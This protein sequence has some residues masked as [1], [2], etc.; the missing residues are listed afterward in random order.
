MGVKELLKPLDDVFNESLDQVIAPSLGKIYGYMKGLEKPESE[1]DEYIYDLYGK[2]RKFFS[3]TYITSGME[4]VFNEVIKALE[5]SSTG[6]IILP[7]LFGGGK[8]HL[9]LALLHAFQDPEAIL[10]AEPKDTAEKLYENLKNLL[11]SKK[12]DKIDIVVIDGDYEKYAPSPIKPLNVGPYTVYTIW[13]YIAHSLG[14]Y[15]IVRDYDEKQAAPSEDALEDLFRDKHALILM[16]EV[17]SGYAVNLDNTQR[18]KL[19]EFFKRLASALQGKNIATVITIPAYYREQTGG[20]ETDELYKD[21]DDFIEVLF[22]AVREQ[23]VIVPPVRYAEEYGG[24]DVVKI[25]RKRIFGEAEISVPADKISDIISHY[26]GVYSLGMFPSTARQIE[27]LKEY[28]PFHPTYIDILIRHI[29]ERRPTTFQRT[30]F[31]ILI[32]RK[33]IRN[34]WQSNRDPD[35]IHAW[36]IDLENGDISAAI[37]GKLQEK[38]Y[39]GYVNKLYEVT[40]KFVN[41]EENL[42]KDIITT[43]FLRTFLYEGASEATKAYPTVNEVYWAVYDR[44]HNVEPARLELVLDKL[45]EDPDASYIVKGD[46]KVY[47]TTLVDIGEILKKRVEEALKSYKN[48]VVEKLK[49]ELKEVLV[50][51]DEPHEPFSK[52]YTTFM[53]SVDL[54]AGFK[55]E[56][57]PEHKAIV[58]LGQLEDSQ[59]AHNLIL[60]YKN[61][62]NVV[63]VLDSSDNKGFEEL[64][65]AAAWLYVIDNI[66]KKNEL[67]EMYPDENIRKWN[68]DK[69]K[70]IR[71]KKLNDLKNLATKVLNRVWYPNEEN[72]SYTQVTVSKK[73]LLGNIRDA[74]IGEKILDPDQ[75]DLKVFLEKLGSAGKKL[76]QWT[77]VSTITDLFL[78]N[79]RLWIASKDDVLKVLKRLYDSLEIMIMREGKIYW[80]NIC[81]ETR[82]EEC[83][84]GSDPAIESLKDN[85]AIARSDIMF[86]E[87]VK[88]LISSEGVESQADKTVT[89]QYLVQIGGS[90]NRLRDLYKEWG[91]DRLYQVLKDPRNKLTLKVEVVERGFILELDKEYKETSPGQPVEVKVSVKPIGDYKGIVRL[92]ADTGT[93]ERSEGVPP[94]DAR[95]TLTSPQR[96]DVYKY[97][98]RASDGKFLRNATL[99]INVIGEYET[100]DVDLSEY[101]AAP[102]DVI[103]EVYDIK[104]P[105]HVLDIKERMLQWLGTI[106]VYLEASG[107]EGKLKVNIDGTSFDDVGEIIKGLTQLKGVSVEAKLKVQDPKPIDEHRASL[108]NS[109]RGRFKGVKIKAKRKVKTGV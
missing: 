26:Q 49:D 9:L 37:L 18:G 30:R 75:V 98:I 20:I 81:E 83:P 6:P 90:K 67:V 1:L 82:S 22:D 58:Y 27:L 60:G 34:L 72:V 14:R 16:D 57:S 8:T 63:V 76:D 21:I 11:Q 87:F 2:S 66:I 86:E 13:G 107:L 45:I 92:E 96:E 33:V 105:Q 38:D 43:I 12:I 73:S 29:A 91:K 78:R 17:L 59:Q 5:N 3:I 77:Q 28:Y 64:L 7:S 95:W 4:K 48:K 52:D 23:G 61:Y 85:D 50:S 94:F 100:I 102:G 70:G 108:I 97:E 101:A 84:G 54:H 104:I 31:A 106:V 46:D 19:L 71:K 10:F 51:N 62:R 25:L 41:E 74:L 80:K 89:K 65:E 47:F 53:T 68:E 24:S 69:L 79:P 103:D 36:S 109:I 35:F 55:P 99:K 32:T 88:Q 93:I 15:D 44:E 39:K 40:K 42:A 56:D